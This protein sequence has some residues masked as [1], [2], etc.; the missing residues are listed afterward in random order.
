VVIGIDLWGVC[1][2][3]WYHVVIDSVDKSKPRWHNGTESWLYLVKVRF[4]WQTFHGLLCYN[5]VSVKSLSITGF[6]GWQV[7]CDNIGLHPYN[8]RRKAVPS[9]C[10]ARTQ[11]RPTSCGKWTIHAVSSITGCLFVTLHLVHSLND[12]HQLGRWP[13]WCTILVY[14]TFIPTL[15]MFWAN[16]C[17][18]SGGQLY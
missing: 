4:W 5:D 12:F 10:E 2:G 18:S 14:N 7:A 17:S 16:T 13:T 15:Y 11:S 6:R 8:D 3:L 1:F 9:H